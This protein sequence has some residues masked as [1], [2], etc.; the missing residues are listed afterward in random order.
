MSKKFL[1]NLMLVTVMAVLCFAVAVTASATDSTCQSSDTGKHEWYRTDDYGSGYPYCTETIPYECMWCGTRKT[2][3]NDNVLEHKWVEDDM[4]YNEPTC[5]NDGYKRYACEYCGAE[6]YEYFPATGEHDWYRCDYDLENCEE[7][8]WECYV[9]WNCSESRIEYGPSNHTWYE[10]EDC[11][12]EP[13]CGNLGYKL[14]RCENCHTTKTE[15]IPATEN[16]S[17]Y[18]SS[19]QDATCTEDGTKNLNCENCEAKD[20]ET[21]VD[22]GSAL[23]HNF[24]ENW[25]VLTEATCSQSGV[26]VRACKRCAEIES[27]VESAYGHYDNDGNGKCD[28]CSVVL[29]NSGTVTPDDTAPDTP[30]EPTTDVPEEETSNNPFSGFLDIIMNFIQQIKDFFNNIFK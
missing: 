27:Q 7:G 3:P 25:S 30:D 21:V 24:N 20:I 19:N 29:E 26:S 17:Y 13:T 9:C 11:K 14:Y 4:D 10:D 2:V 8:T 6:K 5:K 15:Y 18:W 16:H 12:E 28:E 23:G 1:K 22:E